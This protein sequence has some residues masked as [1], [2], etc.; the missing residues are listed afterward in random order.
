MICFHNQLITV[1]ISGG[2]FAI[3]E[4]TNTADIDV[5]ENSEFIPR[6]LCKVF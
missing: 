6:Q 4:N 1:D 2:Q 3:C 5:V